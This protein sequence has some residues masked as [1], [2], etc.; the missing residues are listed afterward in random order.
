MSWEV[1]HDNVCV[2]VKLIRLQMHYNASLDS[3]VGADLHTFL[4]DP[5]VFTVK[6]VYV[7]ILKGE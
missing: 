1:N 4:A 6:D 2:D 3:E 5:N 7:D